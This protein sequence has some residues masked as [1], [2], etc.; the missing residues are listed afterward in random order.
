VKAA[1]EA[2]S[3]RRLLLT[4]PLCRL[5]YLNRDGGEPAAELESL[6]RDTARELAASKDLSDAQAG[7]L[8][9]DYYVRRTGTHDQIA[10]RMHVTRTVYYQRQHRG[11]EQIAARLEQLMSITEE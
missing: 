9:V 10:E 11:F 7:Q 6:L 1:F 8:L 3:D 4:S 5:P 2:L